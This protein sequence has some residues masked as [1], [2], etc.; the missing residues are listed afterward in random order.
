MDKINAHSFFVL[1]VD[2]VENGIPKGRYYCSD[3]SQEYEFHNMDQ[4]LL[5]ADD[6]L[7]NAGRVDTAAVCKNA[8]IRLNGKIATFRIR[9]LFRRRADWQGSVMWLETRYEE[10]FRGALELLS[11]IRQALVP[12]QKQRMCPSSL[13]IAK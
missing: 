9:V 5:E 3:L 6:L 11:I 10:N 4:F 12:A 1:C 2:A 13:K 8:P 7:N